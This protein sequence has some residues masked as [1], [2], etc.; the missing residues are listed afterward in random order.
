MSL[1]RVTAGRP[2]I[3]AVQAADRATFDAEWARCAPWIEAA[4]DVSGG[5]HW[6]EDIKTMVERREARFWAW[7]N[8]AAVTEVQVWPRAK[9]LLVWLAGGSLEE[10]RDEVLPLMEAHGRENDCTRCYIVGRPGWAKV[11]PGYR[12][13]AVSVAKEL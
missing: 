4:L 10:L 13:V 3:E 12:T 2:D 6:I 7:T 9:F 1:E 11:L 5:T 8:S